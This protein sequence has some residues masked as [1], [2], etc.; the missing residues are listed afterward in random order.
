[1]YVCMYV[2]MYVRA[3]GAGKTMTRP[4]LRITK[5]SQACGGM[6][7]DDRLP[8]SGRAVPENN[9]EVIAS[10]ECNLRCPY[11]PNVKAEIDR[12][13]PSNC[14][15]RIVLQAKYTRDSWSGSEEQT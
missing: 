12:C 13:V 15:K 1:M 11:L 6:R 4:G 2:C 7:E 5:E 14:T 10:D 8:I 3:Q 9:R